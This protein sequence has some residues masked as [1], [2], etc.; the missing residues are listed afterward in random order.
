MM[1]V[2]KRSTTRPKQLAKSLVT[3]MASSVLRTRYPC[4]C[5]KAPPAPSAVD[6][7]VRKMK[8][9]KAVGPDSLPIE[10]L[11]AGGHTA[12]EFV[13]E[14]L[15]ASYASHKSVD[16]GEGILRALQKPGKPAGP[17]ANLRPIVL[18][19]LLRKVLSVVLLNRVRAQVDGY[20]SASQ[21]GFRIGRSTA[22]IVW[23]H[24][25]LAAKVIR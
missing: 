6:K 22:D 23:A 15:N 17:L 24:R 4:L 13:A 7:V 10:V 14:V 16:I 1:I 8:P 19:T 5:S 18:L 25:W 9:G 11:K 3:S 21:A 20:L 2:V 12:A